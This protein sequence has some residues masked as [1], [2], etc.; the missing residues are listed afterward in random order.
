[1]ISVGL[2]RFYSCIT[3]GLSGFFSC[4]PVGLN[5]HNPTLMQLKNPNCT[6]MAGVE[7][8]TLNLADFESKPRFLKFT[9]V[10][11]HVRHFWRVFDVDTVDFGSECSFSVERTNSHNSHIPRLKSCN[12]VKNGIPCRSCNSDI[13]T[14]KTRISALHIPCPKRHTNKKSTFRNVTH[15]C[16]WSG[17]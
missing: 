13:A 1:M 14:F 11:T 12:F 7:D 9:G 10:D 5:S 6:A 16:A 2:R 3:V 15:P 8:S 17:L 4:I